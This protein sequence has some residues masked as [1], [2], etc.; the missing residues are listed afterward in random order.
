MNYKR[1]LLKN[2]MVYID[3]K[4]HKKDI[5]LN[6]GKII[7]IGS[8]LSEECEVIDCSNLKILPSFTDIHVHFRDPGD[9]LSENILTGSKAALKGGYTHVFEMPNTNPVL[10]NYEIMRKHLAD[11]KNSAMCHVIPFSAA[12]IGLNGKVLV[13]TEKIASLEIAGFSDDGKGIQDRE[14]M[15]TI[16][17]EAGK[18]NLVVSAHCEDESEFIDGVGCIFEGEKANDNNLKGINA[19]SEYRMIERDIDII[20]EIHGIHPYRYHVCHISCK[21]SLELIIAAKE[22][23]YNITCEVTPH[24]LIS[25]VSEIDVRDANYKMNPPLRS[26]ADVGFLQKGIKDGYIDVVAS[27]HAPHHKD[28]KNKG[29]EKSAFGI[30]GL[31]LS[32]SLINTYLVRTGLISTERMVEVMSLAPARI[33]GIDKSL[34]IGSP[35]NICIIDDREKVKYE[36]ADIVSKSHN[37]FYLSR[38]LYGKVVATIIEDKIYNW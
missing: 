10:D 16:L 2:G 1:V 18:R 8:N 34:K 23:G 29:F 28:K 4:F 7:D 15:K 38:E 35:A 37:S 33:M 17:I 36:K 25:D 21:E 22:K 9:N 5:L 14:L 24:H 32:F 30:I 13:D 11:I 6:N 27:D 20:S 26:K 19:S 31:E 12:S 3:G